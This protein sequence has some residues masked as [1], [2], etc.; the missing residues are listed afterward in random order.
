[1]EGAEKA[2]CQEGCHQLLGHVHCHLWRG[3][4]REGK[5]GAVTADCQ[6]QS[7]REMVSFLPITLHFTSS[8]IT[9]LWTDNNGSSAAGSSSYLETHHYH[10]HT[11]V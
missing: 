6:P 4:G 1:M 2:V 5:G 8:I 11:R 10:P 3:R 7:I 9:S